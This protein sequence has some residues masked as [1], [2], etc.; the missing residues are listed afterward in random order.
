MNTQPD[1]SGG[2]TGQG[3]RPA[4]L[5]GI[6]AV[7]ALAVLAAVLLL[8]PKSPAPGSEGFPGAA[9]VRPASW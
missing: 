5:I 4:V 3:A 1:N 7:A 2:G 8:K 6:L 9:A